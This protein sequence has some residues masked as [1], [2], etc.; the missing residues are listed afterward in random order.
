MTSKAAQL[1][2][3]DLEEDK[4][5]IV[6]LGSHTFHATY[7]KNFNQRKI[8]R[9][10]VQASPNPVGD[11]NELVNIMAEQGT[12]TPKCISRMILNSPVKIFL[13]HWIFWRWIDWKFQNRQMTEALI[14][15]FSS[16]DLSFFFRNMTLIV[17]LNMLT[18]RL[19]KTELKQLSQELQSERKL[20]S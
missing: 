7:L 4:P 5:F 11:V 8:S 18:K 17:E 19:T 9:L 20:V 2:Q 13:F 12:L 10:I 1:R 14:V 6:P 16:M 3:A 15:L